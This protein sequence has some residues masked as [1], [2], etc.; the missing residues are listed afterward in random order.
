MPTPIRII[1]GLPFV[2]GIIHANGQLLQLE[3]LLLD[4]GSGGTVIKADHLV[5]LGVI[6]LPTDP[7]RFLRGIGGD[8][9]VIEK[10]IEELEVGELHASP[11]TI[12]MGA[13][14]YGFL[15]DGIIGLDFL[16][17]TQAVIDFKALRIRSAK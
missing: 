16:L 7:L 6:P 1:G 15:M 8:E 3:H 13:L 11:F 2:A 5:A 10:S 17:H 4:T 9:A 12:Q 14:E